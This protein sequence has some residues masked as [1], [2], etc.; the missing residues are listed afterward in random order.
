MK[1]FCVWENNNIMDLT[2]IKLEGMDCNDLAQDTDMCCT[3]VN[4]LMKLQIL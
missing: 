1:Y 3:L 2:E 4:I